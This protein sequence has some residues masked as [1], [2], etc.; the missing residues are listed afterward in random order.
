MR[1]SLDK[2]ISVINGELLADTRT[3]KD[4]LSGV[5]TDS[6]SVQPGDIFFAL[7]GDNFDGHNFVSEVAEKGAQV[8]VVSNS[9]IAA[10]AA[11]VKVADTLDALGQLAAWWRS[12]HADIPVSAIVGSSGKTTTKEMAG[13]I[14]TR[15]YSTLTT[16]G[17]FNNLVGLPL[18]LFALRSSH[19]AAVLE[20]GMNCP[21]ENRKLMAIA[22]PDCIA[23]TNIN[24]AHIGMFDSV[25]AH[26]QAEAEPIQY[27][28]PNAL[29]IINADDPLSCQAYEEFGQGRKVW[30]FSTNAPADFYAEEIVPL[31]PYGYEFVLKNSKGDS[32]EVTLKVFGRHNVANA[33]AAAAVAAFHGISLEDTA[34]QLSMFRPRYNRSEVEE[35][36]GLFIIKDYYNAIPAAVI[37]ALRSLGDLEITGRR[38][39][40]LGD[41]LE[42]G[43]H[44]RKFHEDVAE[45]AAQADLTRLYTIG[46][47]GKII[48]DRATQLGVDAQHFASME[49]L[50]AELKQ[51]LKRGD[52]IFIKGSRALRM[53]QLFD[54]LK[55]SVTVT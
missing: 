18:T 21:E 16:K 51:E 35:L 26:Y 47:R 38:F 53:E 17:N 40:V 10:G 9:V 29:L 48:S 19:E 52:L 36:D 6:R 50:A 45:A 8:V 30:R 22:Q 44:E 42:L 37:S 1:V 46:E 31:H 54:L 14:L 55:N 41:M 28:S 43:D 20:L 33:V 11:T 23:L 7:T 13:E 5:T 4:V 12:E 24:H 34:E 3:D 49:S 39:A 15:F 25:R 32:A 27:A 2:L